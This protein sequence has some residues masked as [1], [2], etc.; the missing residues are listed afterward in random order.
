MFCISA[1]RLGG[2]GS[3]WKSCLC[4][5]PIP[6]L[7]S[8]PFDNRTRVITPNGWRYG[9]AGG[10]FGHAAHLGAQCVRVCVA[11]VRERKNGQWWE[12]TDSAHYHRPTG[13]KK[14]G[15]LTFFVF[16]PPIFGKPCV[17][18]TYPHLQ[19]QPQKCKRR[20][21]VG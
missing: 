4:I 3:E 17:C 20:E 15:S 19:P 9:R 11:V 7:L 21:W 16:R 13:P 5:P 10:V 14:G 2:C 6:S 1:A 12:E 8:F 18:G